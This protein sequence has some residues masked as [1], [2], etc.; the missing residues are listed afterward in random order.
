MKKIKYMQHGPFNTRDLVTVT[1]GQSPQQGIKIEEM[2][3]RIRILDA[4]EAGKDF[5]ILE[6]EDFKLLKTILEEFPFSVANKDLFTSLEEIIN[7]NVVE[8]SKKE[9]G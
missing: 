3:R 4:F 7:S 2:R 5:A 9:R 8:L 6:E 1:V